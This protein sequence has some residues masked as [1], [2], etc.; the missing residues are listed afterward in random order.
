MQF[1]F[2]ARADANNHFTCNLSPLIDWEWEY[3][4]NFQPAV[5]RQ[6][7][8]VKRVYIFFSQFRE[9]ALTN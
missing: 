3:A 5:T 4:E 8:Q 7:C 2:S 6:S 9:Q 1:L